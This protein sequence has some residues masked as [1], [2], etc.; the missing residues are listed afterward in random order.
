MKQTNKLTIKEIPNLDRPYEKFLKYGAHSLSDSELL[1]IL[2]KNGSREMNCLEL[3][4]TLLSQHKSGLSGFNYLERASL[5]EL[6]EHSGI[7]RVKA[8]QIKAIIELSKRI[9]NN[10]QVITKVTTPKDIYNILV[11]DMG[12]LEKEE[13]RVV[14]LD[15]KNYIKS[16]VTIVNGSINC[17]AVSIKE[18]L[19]EPIKQLASGI[20]LVH[21]HPS[22]ESSPSR[23]DIQLTKKVM[24]YASLFDID[25]KDH[26]IICKNEYTSL[27]EFDES[28][29]YGRKLL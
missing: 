16:I 24:D 23:Q 26:I 17:S 27:R 21:N 18:I 20:I 25:L 28:I 12:H 11:N 15:I 10:R 22:G 13:I 19:S 2:I 8:I 4:K 7:G 1:A 14:I 5:S 9:A 3:S 29:F 6:M